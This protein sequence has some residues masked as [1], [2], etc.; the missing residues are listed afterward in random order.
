MFITIIAKSGGGIEQI[1]LL[2]IEA[3]SWLGNRVRTPA[4]RGWGGYANF[5]K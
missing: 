5:N 2:C 1:L 3:K 4:K